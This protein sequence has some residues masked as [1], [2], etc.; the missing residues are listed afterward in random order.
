MLTINLKKS[1][2]I[3]NG[4]KRDNEKNRLK[5]QFFFGRDYL[6]KFTAHE[7]NTKTGIYGFCISP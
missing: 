7:K 5:I 1:I 6:F 4:D 2:V 3:R